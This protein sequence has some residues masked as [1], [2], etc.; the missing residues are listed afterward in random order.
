MCKP[1]FKA[2]ACIK[3]ATKKIR[4][5]FSPNALQYEWIHYYLVHSEVDKE[6]KKIIMYYRI[7]IEKARSCHLILVDL[8]YAEELIHYALCF[9]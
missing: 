3:Y 9:L 7:M 4:Q 2:W 5:E 1:C 6:N 8:A